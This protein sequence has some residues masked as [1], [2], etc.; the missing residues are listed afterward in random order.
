MMDQWEAARAH[1]WLWDWV[2]TGGLLLKHV[3]DTS[4][5]SCMWFAN[6]F[7]SGF[8]LS[9]QPISRLFTE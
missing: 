4:P 3:L 6:T 8:P 1:A 9:V 7:P 2:P 5:P